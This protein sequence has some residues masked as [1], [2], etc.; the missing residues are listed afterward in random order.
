MKL[1]GFIVIY[2][3]SGE[4]SVSSNGKRIWPRIDL[5]FV[6]RGIAQV[7]VVVKE[8]QETHDCVLYAGHMA[9][10]VKEGGKSVE[11]VM[12]WAMGLGNIQNQ[13]HH[14]ED[15]EKVIPYFL[16]HLLGSDVKI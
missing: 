11:P 2:I 10:E 5:N 1:H 7:K 8:P 6:P 12:A 9:M 3:V 15:D 4:P 16:K 14:D 13:S